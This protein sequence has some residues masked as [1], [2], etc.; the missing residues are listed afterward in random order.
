MKKYCLLPLLIAVLLFSGCASQQANDAASQTIPE[1]AATPSAQAQQS[2]APAETQGTIE[3]DIAPLLKLAST[4]VKSLSYKYMGPETDNKLY[5]IYLK[6]SKM[7]IYPFDR[8]EYSAPNAYDVIYL[9]TAAKTAVS[10][11][12]HQTCVPKGKRSDLTYSAVYLATP[13]DWL[14]GITSAK[15]AGSETIEKR[16]VTIVETN[17]G[18]MWIENFYGVPVKIEKDG[19]TYTFQGMGFNGVSDSQVA[20][21]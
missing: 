19:T 2:S 6:G 3:A 17:K 8:N 10:Y 18:K 14:S 13:I 20:P 21:Q 15:K 7:S 16:A 11:C 12:T 9:D 1:K 4:K 5:N